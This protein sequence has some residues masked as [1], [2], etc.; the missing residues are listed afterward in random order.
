MSWSKLGWEESLVVMDEWKKVWEEIWLGWERR[1]VDWIVLF[2]FL[3][4]LWNLR[5]S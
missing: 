3:K 2:R 4:I 5:K 1:V